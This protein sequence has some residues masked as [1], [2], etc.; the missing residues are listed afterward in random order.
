MVPSVSPEGPESIPMD[1]NPITTDRL[2]LRPL[3]PSHGDDVFALLSDPAVF[4]WAT[5]STRE[6]SDVWLKTKLESKKTINYVVCLPGSAKDSEEVIGVLGAHNIPELGY[7][8]KPHTWGKGYA[9]EALKAWTQWYWKKFSDGH[10]ILD[11]EEKLYLKALT[12]PG[13]DSSR[14]VLRK[15]GFKW[16]GEKELSEEEKKEAEKGKRVVLEEFRMTKPEV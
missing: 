12:G 1:D 16:Y 10:P 13:G 3:A 6:Q 14:N 11:P 8:F 5:P 15:C 9:T 7:L 4:P 2:I